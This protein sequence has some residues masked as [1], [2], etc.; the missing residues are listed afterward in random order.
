MLVSFLKQ[1]TYEEKR[2]LFCIQFQRF[3]SMNGWFCC[4]GPVIRQHIGA[5]VCGRLKFLFACSGSKRESSSCPPRSLPRLHFSKVPEKMHA[6][7]LQ[8]TSS[9]STCYKVIMCLFCN[10]HSH[11]PLRPCPTPLPSFPLSVTTI[12][13]V[14]HLLNTH[15][16]DTT[17][18]SNPLHLFCCKD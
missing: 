8:R 16:Q 18:S 10:H 4:F 14:Q 12:L 17:F 15:K 13:D 3:Q 1:S 7:V 5:G 9:S 11:Q 2:F 6:K